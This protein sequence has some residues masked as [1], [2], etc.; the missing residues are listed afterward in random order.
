[1][2]SNF[3]FLH[4]MFSWAGSWKSLQITENN[5]WK[6]QPLWY[7]SVYSVQ[8]NELDEWIF[9]NTPI[10]WIWLQIEPDTTN[11]GTVTTKYYFLFE[12]S[13]IKIILLPSF[14]S[15][16]LWVFGQIYFWPDRYEIK[17]SRSSNQLENHF[18][19][20]HLMKGAASTKLDWLICLQRTSTWDS[21]NRRKWQ[22]IRRVNK[23]CSAGYL[24]GR[25]LQDPHGFSR[26][27]YESL[28]LVRF[29]INNLSC[30][31]CESH[32]SLV[33]FQPSLHF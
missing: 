33:S 28:C 22:Q 5:A 11:G 1:M 12:I 9:S 24:S 26:N 31:L 15:S 3:L 14:P 10:Y 23:S 8:L 7:S 20:Q 30:T 4:I 6:P 29:Y 32:A 18:L 2:Y 17:V 27:G 25:G 13:K 19:L 21:H 16:S